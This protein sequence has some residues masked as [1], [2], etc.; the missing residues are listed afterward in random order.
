MDLSTKI[1]ICFAT[2]V[3]LPPLAYI[4]WRDVLNKNSPNC[5]RP[6]IHP[7]GKTTNPN[8]LN[9]RPRDTYP[10][11]DSPLNINNQRFEGSVT[12]IYQI[13]PDFYKAIMNKSKTF[14]IRLKSN[15]KKGDII[16]Y[17]CWNGE[18]KLPDLECTVGY[19]TTFTDAYVVISLTNVK[20]VEKT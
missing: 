8:Q 9:T 16:R 3:L 11:E 17:E 14:E 7:I 18:K 2:I 6:S 13:T 10:F 19:I 5:P 12:H 4:F 1:L 15:A 20:V